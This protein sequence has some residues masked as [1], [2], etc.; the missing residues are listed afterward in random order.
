MGGHNKNC[1]EWRE[2]V[3]ERARQI[4]GF[5][6]EKCGIKLRRFEAVGHHRLPRSM[7][8]PHTAQNCQIKCRK[9]EA[10]DKHWVSQNSK[11]VK[12]FFLKNDLEGLRIFAPED[13]FI[14][15]EP[16]SFFRDLFI[17]SQGLGANTLQYQGDN[18]FRRVLV[19]RASHST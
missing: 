2:A 17:E 19:L 11:K 7:S 3:A 4:G 13:A 8:G 12:P 9:C 5:K 14:D 18:S 6:C 10:K 1:N 16:L 15:M